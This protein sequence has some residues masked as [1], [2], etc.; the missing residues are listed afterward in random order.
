M[1]EILALLEAEDPRQ[2]HRRRA[3]GARAGALRAAAALRR[4]QRAA[5]SA[6][7]SLERHDAR[8]RSRHRHVARRAGDRLRLRRLPLD[9]SAR[10]ADA[11]VDPDR[12]RRRLRIGRSASGSPRR[13]A[14]ILVD[15]STDLRAQALAYDV[16]RVDAILFTHSHAD[17]VLGLDDVRR[18]NLMQQ[19]AIPCFARRRHARRPAADV[20]VH[21]R[22]HAAQQGGG[23]PQLSLFRDRRRRSRSA[24]SRSCRCRCCTAR[25]R[26][27]ASG[28]GSFAYLTDCNRI[29]DAS[30]PLL[31]GV[32]T[33]VLDALRDR[34]HSDAFQRRRSARGRRAPRRRAH[35]LHAHLPRSAAR[36]DL[37]APAG[38]RGVGL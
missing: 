33:L 3:P 20:R 23:M 27:S 8:H 25:C 9:R 31:D 37:R 1:I 16:R 14:T 17:H 11:A 5:A 36:R 26:S 2:P 7:S 10:S 34:P 32:R 15:T 29:P 18:F 12:S 22:R 28:I 35:L 13:C 6:S 30:W 4:G 24:A 19:S 38:R 21:L